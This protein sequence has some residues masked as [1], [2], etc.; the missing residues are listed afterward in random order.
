MGSLDI[1]MDPDLPKGQQYRQI[2]PDRG[3]AKDVVPTE[4]RSCLKEIRQEAE[5]ARHEEGLKDKVEAAKWRSVEQNCD[6]DQYRQLCLG[7]EL[8]GMPPGVIENVAKE[9]ADPINRRTRRR[10]VHKATTAEVRSSSMPPTAPST[11]DEFERD[12]RSACPD[13][14]SKYAYLM[15]I[16]RGQACISSLFEKG[17]VEEHLGDIMVSLDSGWV[18]DGAPEGTAAAVSHWMVALPKAFRFEL[19]AGFLAESEKVAVH[20]LFESLSEFDGR[21]MDKEAI[22]AARAKFCAQ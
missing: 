18:R 7:A 17:G 12:W 6:Y 20:R 10:G 22:T 8:K 15:L 4:R 9:K 16:S 14:A 3:F 21:G 13:I 2:F 5:A 1:L 19:A 11:R